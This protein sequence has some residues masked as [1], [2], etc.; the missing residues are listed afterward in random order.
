MIFPSI[1]LGL[2][3]LGIMQIG[4]SASEPQVTTIIVPINMAFPLLPTTAVIIN[5]PSPPTDGTLV[6][7]T[8]S[9]GLVG[10]VRVSGTI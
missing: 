7:V 2:L 5:N 3:A 10:I 1:V 4:L 8:G 6:I 9:D